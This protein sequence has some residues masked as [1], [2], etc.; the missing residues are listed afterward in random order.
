MPLKETREEYVAFIIF[1]DAG[2]AITREGEI[3]RSCS[4]VSAVALSLRSCR[5]T[6]RRRLTPLPSIPSGATGLDLRGEYWA[7]FLA[8]W[9]RE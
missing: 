8:D 2:H 1:G 3:S 4:S 9:R 7:M 5:P 6:Q